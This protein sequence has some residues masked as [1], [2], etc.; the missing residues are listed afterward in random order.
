MGFF[1]KTPKPPVVNVPAD[2]PAS[3]TTALLKQQQDDRNLALLRYVGSSNQTGIDILR[4]NSGPS[5]TGL[6]P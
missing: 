6:N 3:D 2:P 4:G 5:R 1:F